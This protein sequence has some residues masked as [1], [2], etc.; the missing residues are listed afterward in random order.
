MIKPEIIL[1]GYQ[2]GVF[3]MGISDG[4]DKI[5]WFS[6]N[7][8]AIIPIDTFHIP[9]GLARTLRKK[10][11]EIKIDT[12]FTEVLEGCARRETTWINADIIES[13]IEMFRLGYAHSVEAWRDG[14]L[15]GGLYGVALGGAF[16]GES[17]FHYKTDA[18]KIALHALVERLKTRGY[19]LLDTQWITEH[20][21]QFGTVEIPR[22]EYLRRLDAALSKDCVFV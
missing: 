7:P 11:Y 12:A 16:F 3:P 13:Y 20:L 17:M 14:E 2:Q 10:I 1:A 19:T 21:Q 5:A 18:S 8:R 15:A 4:T 6:P 22:E 9:H